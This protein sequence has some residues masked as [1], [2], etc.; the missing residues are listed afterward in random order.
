MDNEDKLDE[1]QN[2]FSMMT[3]QSIVVE[4]IPQISTNDNED[5][6]DASSISPSKMNQNNNVTV[7]QQSSGFEII[8]DDYINNK[9]KQSN[10]NNKEEMLNTNMNI[11]QEKNESIN[12]LSMIIDQ[13]M[14]QKVESKESTV[15]QN[16]NLDNQNSNP[17]NISLSQLNNNN[18]YLEIEDNGNTM[19]YL[20]N[21]RKYEISLISFIKEGNESKTKKKILCYRRFSNFVSFYT[22]LQLV[23]PHYIFPKLSEKNFFTKFTSDTLFLERRRKQIKF[24]INFLFNHPVLSQS[25]EFLKFIKDAEFDE[26]YFKTIIPLFSYPEIESLTAGSLISKLSSLNPFSRTQSSKLPKS[27]NQNELSKNE[28]KYKDISDKIN[29]IFIEL[30]NIEISFGEEQKSLN[31]IDR[32]ILFLKSKKNFSNGFDEERQYAAVY[33][34]SNNLCNCYSMINKKT[35]ISKIVDSF[36]EFNLMLS[37]I[38]EGF[39]RYNEFIKKFEHI[40]MAIEQARANS[41]NGVE[42][43]IVDKVPEIIERA[44]EDKKTFEAKLIEEI[45]CFSTNNSNTFEDLL[46]Q[47]YTLMKQI[48]RGE[49]NVLEEC[50]KTFN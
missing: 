7:N 3:A 44:N 33:Q 37:G 38:C 30:N 34:I 29:S 18:G 27:K 24:F 19:S 50:Q 48:N 26:N 23:Y 32:S 15:F 17:Y 25:K 49:L 13:S 40:N 31:E 42:R 45:I 10:S 16:V 22:A 5:K 46:E 12:P 4:Q 2:R 47:F 35:S 41:F 1:N 8:D 28:S 11:S 43:K 6:L 39:N 9:Q 20:G 36:D 21:V 14:H